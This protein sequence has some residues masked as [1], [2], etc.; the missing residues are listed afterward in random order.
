MSTLGARPVGARGRRG[1]L[2]RA[3]F[4]SQPETYFA[5]ALVI[6]LLLVGQG[7]SGNFLSSGHLITILTIA[8]F[9][10]F[11][12]AS[13][14]LVLLTGGIDLSIA[15]VFTVTGILL[16]QWSQGQVSKLAWVLPVLLGIGLLVGLINAIGIM[17]LRIPPL[18]MT[19]GMGS[20]LGGW[21]QA[22]TSGSLSGQA[23]SVIRS[24]STGSAV[25]GIPWIVFM[26]LGLAILLGLMLALTSFGRRIYALGSNRLASRLAAVP[27]PWTLIGVYAL[28][29]LFAAIAGILGAGYTGYGSFESGA[30]YLLPSI[31]AA[32]IGGVAITGG[33]GSYTGACAG[34][35]VLTTLTTI[36][37]IVSVPDPVR[38][39]LYGAVIL[40]ALLLYGQSSTLRRWLDVGPLVWRRLS[41]GRARLGA[42]RE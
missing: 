4:R 1:V 24:L 29:G 33:R 9:L 7:L 17:W 11:M 16:G 18:I 26:W 36:L 39:I 42:A 28:S 41:A 40:L 13:Q 21:I 32:A 2:R 10:G 38:D 35:L 23:P 20:V 15:G 19:L 37:T 31:A 22:Y 14:T 27:I 25:G 3:L 6:V 8:A 12:A 5:Y 30:E 34:V